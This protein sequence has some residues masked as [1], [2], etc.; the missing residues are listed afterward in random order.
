MQF[1]IMKNLIIL[2]LLL[3]SFSNLTLFAQEPENE[4]EELR[5]GHLLQID[6]FLYSN[7]AFIQQVGSYNSITTIQEQQGI[8]SNFINVEQDDGANI[9][10]IEQTGSGHGTFLIQNGCG[11]KA[12]IWEEGR[13]TISAIEQCG[14]DNFIN[15]YISNQS[16]VINA[17]ILRQ[18]GNNN[19]IEFA[20]LDNSGILPGS[21]PWGTYIEQIGSDLSISAIFDTYNC[22]V[23]IK[24]QS[25]GSGGMNITVTHTTFNFPMK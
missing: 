12:N 21:W 9:G 5:N 22:P 7:L 11:N 10:Y 14:N 18:N 6:N 16:I 2:I 4:L 23:Y 17:A 1:G 20:S 24:Q 3:V 8:F 19:K 15:S 25:N 13:F